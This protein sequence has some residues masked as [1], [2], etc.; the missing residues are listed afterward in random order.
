[1][2]ASSRLEAFRRQLAADLV[3]RN[4]VLFA[5]LYGNALETEAFQELELGVF[6]DDRLAPASSERVYA[7]SLSDVYRERLHFP[8]RVL[9]L[10]YAPLHFRY[11]VSC[12][13]P[14]YARSEEFLARYRA[15][16]WHAWFDFQPLVTK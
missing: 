3:K 1:L 11:R 14:A 9:V 15:R 8:V 7:R 13:V 10:N 12:G 16:A 6:L 4:E 2:S 5:L